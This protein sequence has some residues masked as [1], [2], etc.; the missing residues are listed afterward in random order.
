MAH[1]VDQGGDVRRS[2]I[3]GVAFAVV[4]AATAA[5]AASSLDFGK[6]RDK[7]LADLSPDLF[8]VGRPI[9]QSSTASISQAQ[10]QADPTQLVTLAKGLHARVV[11][12]Q[13]PT[14]FDQIALWPN[15][16]N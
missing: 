14:N 9:A 12:A 5:G 2:L 11:T 16:R 8:G 4:L 7:Q 3:A 13:L 10:A 1:V 6:Y 15:D